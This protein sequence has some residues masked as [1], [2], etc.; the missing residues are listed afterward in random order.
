LSHP[1]TLTR[2]EQNKTSSAVQLKHLPTGL[3]I[4]CQET[5][6][7]EQNR[8]RARQL[9]ARKLDELQ[10]GE[11]GVMANVTR[12]N[13]AKK[14]SA[15]KKRRRKYKKL[16]LDGSQ[17]E[18]EDDGNLEEDEGEAE[19]GEA[20]EGRQQAMLGDGSLPGSGGLEKSNV[21]CCG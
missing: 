6:S 10:N 1:Q 18:D 11:G 20:E 14:A 19:S 7:R 5:R 15:A 9:L 13:S 8:D 2:G 16:A 12:R 17:A 4:K 21:A 3:V